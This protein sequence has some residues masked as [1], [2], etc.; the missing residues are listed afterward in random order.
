MNNCVSTITKLNDTGRLKGVVNAYVNSFCAHDESWAERIT[1]T[2]SKHHFDVLVEWLSYGRVMKAINYTITDSS[3][4]LRGDAEHQTPI[5]N[6]LW[7]SQIKG[8]LNSDEIRD[9]EAAETMKQ[10]TLTSQLIDART[11]F[12]PDERE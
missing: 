6:R 12:A 2:P 7:R 1:I 5:L 10:R 8:V 9:Y 11:F 4:N 3:F